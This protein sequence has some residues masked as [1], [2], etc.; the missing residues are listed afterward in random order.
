[1]SKTRF[2]A[3]ALVLSVAASQANSLHL[4]A[5]SGKS[6][7][8]KTAPSPTKQPTA[9][10][11]DGLIAPVALY[12]DQLLAQMLMAAGTPNRVADL[13]KWLKTKPPFTGTALQEAAE[14]QGFEPP[15]VLLVLF[16]QVVEFMAKNMEW[17]TQIGR[18]F[19][20]DR[21][22]V[23]ASTQRLRQDAL[24][25]GKLKSTDQQKITL[26]TVDSGEHIIVIEPANPQ[27][28]YVPHYNTQTV[29]STPPTT[30]TV[31]VQEDDD[32]SAAIAAG[33]IGFTAGI[34]IG[35]AV[36]NDYYYG[37]YGW[38]GAPYM[39][40]G[41]WN[42]YYEEREDAREDYY[43]AREDRREDV[44]D[45]REDM[46]ENR[47]D[48]RSN[49]Q[50][51]RTDRAQNRQESGTSQAAAANYQ[52]RAQSGTR[53]TTAAERSGTKS[54]AFSGYSSGKSERSASSRGQRSR[55]TSRS[56]GGGGRRR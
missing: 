42:N 30:T 21:N 29:Y 39:Y 37:P 15:L 11:I 34:A 8:P 26:Q 55:S 17:T 51:Q 45:H 49:T 9:V 50:E 13:D 24:K 4:F 43:D 20:S 31:I 3:G 27:I 22:G 23:L 10:E 46:S 7:T 54:D 25:N 14:K 36:N 1:M 53:S 40:G 44:A 19:S 32:D 2:L 28:V 48:R 18:A 38:H 35:A 6:T 52:G 5:Q 47:N 16:P 41:G 56:G 33:I 12:P